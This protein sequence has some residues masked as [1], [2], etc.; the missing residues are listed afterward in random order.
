[1]P[2]KSN[3]TNKQ[4]KENTGDPA[5]RGQSKGGVK[6]VS[7]DSEDEL[8][9]RLRA[10]YTDGVDEPT[11]DTKLGSHPNRNTNKPKIDKPPYG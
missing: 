11:I 6:P 4:S 10:E 5:G 7:P 8:H 9:E 3:S 1:M 2:Y